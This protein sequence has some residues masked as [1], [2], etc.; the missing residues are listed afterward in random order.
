[1]MDKG[2][3]L[4]QCMICSIGILHS[5]SGHVPYVDETSI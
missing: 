5:H 4:N 1:M 3:Q 2:D